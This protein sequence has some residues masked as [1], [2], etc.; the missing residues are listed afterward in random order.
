MI[1]DWKQTGRKY[2][3]AEWKEIGTV[4]TL[5]ENESWKQGVVIFQHTG[6]T[7]HICLYFGGE[8]YEGLYAPYT[9]RDKQLYDADHEKVIAKDIMLNY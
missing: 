8:E 5:E 3:D 4:T 6:F 7:G 1:A 2:V 9:L